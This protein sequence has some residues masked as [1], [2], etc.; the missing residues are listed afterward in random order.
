MAH[1]QGP[2]KGQR[3]DRELGAVVP[4]REPGKHRPTSRPT[5]TV[6]EAEKRAP[7]RRIDGPCFRPR[8]RIREPFSRAEPEFRRILNRA[9][10]VSPDAER[11]SRLHR[12]NGRK[13]TMVPIPCHTT[14]PESLIVWSK[15]REGMRRS[16]RWWR[17]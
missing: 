15:F 3:C 8:K 4:F 14:G 9:P 5:G 2:P 17:I 7:R 16:S 10:D 1:N 11:T 13:K 6:P 12:S